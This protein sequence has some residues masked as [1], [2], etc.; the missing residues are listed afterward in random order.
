MKDEDAWSWRF[1]G[2]VRG[3]AGKQA[4]NHQASPTQ[5]SDDEE[6]SP[7]FQPRVSAASRE[8]EKLVEILN[9]YEHAPTRRKDGLMKDVILAHPP[10]EFDCFDLIDFSRSGTLTANLP[11]QFVLTLKNGSIIGRGLYGKGPGEDGLE[12]SERDIWRVWSIMWSDGHLRCL[13]CGCEW[14]PQGGIPEQCL[15]CLG[16][17]SVPLERQERRENKWCDR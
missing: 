7:P 4:K 10:E 15:A 5:S 16:V 13:R 6:S 3:T 11:R 9:A 8:A 17:L 14:R 2:P 12:D 1:A